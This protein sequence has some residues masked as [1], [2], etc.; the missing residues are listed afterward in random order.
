MPKK[1]KVAVVM[2]GGWSLGAFTGGAVWELVRQL[3]AN[4]E[5]DQYDRCEIDVLAG[6]GAGA[7]VAAALL[8][9]L[10]N[11][12]G[13]AVAAAI[14]RVGEAQRAAWLEGVDFTRLMRNIE[15]RKPSLLDRGA[16]D[17]LATEL[18]SWP[19]GQQ[20]N[21]V[22]LGDR[23]LLGMTLLNFNGVPIRSSNTPALTDTLHTTLFRDYRTFCF[24]FGNSNTAPLPRWRHVA[25]ERV[26]SADA[27]REIAATAVASG[28]FPIAFEPVVLQR[29]REEYGHLWPDELAERDEFPFTYGDGGTFNHMPM[30][31]AMDLISVQ[32]ANEPPGSFERVLIFIDPNLSGSKH[33]FG[34]KFHLPYMVDRDLAPFDR[35]DVVPAD[36][37][38]HLVA[39]TN[40]FG[41]LARHQS[42]FEDF[43][44][45][46]KVNARHGWRAELRAIVTELT[47]QL[48]HN[49]DAGAFAQRVEDRLDCVLR[50]ARE[51]AHPASPEVDTQSAIARVAFEQTGE[52]VAPA[53]LTDANRLAFALMA[54]IDQVANLRG[55]EPVRVIV[56]GPTEYRPPDGSPNIAVKLAG[57]FFVNFGGF[58]DARFRVH[59]FDAGRA[60]AGSALAAS[61]P[62]LA[63]P[64]D[65]PAYTPWS[66]RAPS[67]E[68]VPAARDRFVRRIAGLTRQLLE[69]KIGYLGVT[70]AIAIVAHYV[71]PKLVRDTGPG[72]RMAIVR[73]E[74]TPA[75]RDLDFYLAGSASGDRGGDARRVGD[76]VVL[77]TVLHYSDTEILGPHVS[78]SPPGW[79]VRLAARGKRT[80][81]PFIE[82]P[83]P[84]PDVLRANADCGL[85]IHRIRV[86]WEARTMSAWSEEDALKEWPGGYE[87]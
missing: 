3:H 32:D 35:H 56:V 47:E 51:L 55:K 52:P 28:A 30:R 14:A 50:Q 18:L 62:L 21:P 8:R 27:W 10:A 13:F 57:D 76:V 33:A 54:L 48:E 59:D 2:A 49:G 68:A 87:V 37:A 79:V 42:S 71:T 43:V 73:I 77:H 41:V 9:T 4:R 46:A 86:D 1:L 45:A 78:A 44:A 38:A 16:I 20:A 26:H 80:R 84:H 7:L 29:Y 81:D 34:L 60:L 17:S 75:A 58:F 40:R 70:Q 53:R 15:V 83:L 67:L 69:Y 74:V 12:E 31:E 85:P 66:D 24:D 36:P 11:P 72:R 61:T 23:V 25:G 19:A 63:D 39:I 82:I 6:A 64:N 22:L 65:R 5:R